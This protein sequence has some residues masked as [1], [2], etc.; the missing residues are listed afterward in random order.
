MKREGLKVKP[1]MTNDRMIKL[2]FPERS[3][4]L[5]RNDIPTEMGLSAIFGVKLCMGAEIKLESHLR[6]GMKYRLRIVSSND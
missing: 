4:S 5:G 1:K 6:Y 2:F 3:N